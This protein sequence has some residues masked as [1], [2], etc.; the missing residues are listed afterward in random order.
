MWSQ[1]GFPMPHEAQPECVAIP[2]GG[3][4]HGKQDFDYFAG[5]SA[6]KTGA[7]GLCLHMVG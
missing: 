5:I 7:K 3:T 6:E 4:Y 2:R 1:E